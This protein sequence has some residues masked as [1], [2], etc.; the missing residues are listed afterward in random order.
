MRRL[1]VQA[2]QLEECVKRSMHALPNKPAFEPGELLLLQLTK[3]DAAAA[4]KLHARIEHVLGL[5]HGANSVVNATL[6]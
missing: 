3:T 1:N 5:Y 4:G 6:P 2:T